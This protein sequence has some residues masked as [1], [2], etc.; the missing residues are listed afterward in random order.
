[1][2]QVV[3]ALVDGY[4]YREGRGCDVEITSVI[5]PSGQQEVFGIEVTE[6]QHSKSQRPVVYAELV[7]LVLDTQNQQAAGVLRQALADLR[8][9][10]RSPIDTGFHCFRAVEC[11]RQFFVEPE[12]PDDK[13]SWERMGEKL[14]IE[15]FWTE[16][17]RLFAR[18]Q[19]HGGFPSM[20]GNQRVD[21][22]MRA[23]KVVDR[24]IVYT[25]SGY[26]S[27]PEDQIPEF[28]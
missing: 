1:M 11:L 23:W 10:I 4:G 9:T 21:M 14:G 19:W 28:R 17:I 13:G 2:A 7:G 12:D 15:H 20:S 5:T 6:L 24:F 3:Q 8:E 22:M 25:K 27:F 18:P 16:P 26:Q